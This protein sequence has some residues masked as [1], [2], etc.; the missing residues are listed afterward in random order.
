M[1]ER[2]VRGLEARYREE[3]APLK[4]KVLRLGMERLRAAAQARMRS[5]RL[6]NAYHDAQRAYDSFRE[7]RAGAAPSESEAK[8]AFRKA[9]KHC[10]PD[11]V[12]EAYRA[13]AEATFQALERA[14]ASGYTEA[15]QATAQALEDWGFPTQSQAQASRDSESLRKAVEELDV[16]IRRLRGSEAHQVLEE[17]GT[18]DAA[19]E[20]WIRSLRRR[21]RQLTTE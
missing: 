21:V 11:R 3:V 9:S 19:I 15:V 6:R 8:A 4:E 5:A 17:V 7:A 16:S 2:R 14:H 20:S 10:H 1:L 18:L 12:P 13:E